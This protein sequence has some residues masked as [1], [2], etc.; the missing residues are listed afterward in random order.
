VA[1]LRWA[2][3]D[4]QRLAPPLQYAPFPKELA[5]RENQCA[6]SHPIASGS[7]RRPAFC[8]FATGGRWG[9]ISFDYLRSAVQIG[10]NFIEVV[11]PAQAPSYT[12][13][14]TCLRFPSIALSTA[15]L[16]EVQQI[17]PLVLR[18][19]HVNSGILLSSF[20]KASSRTSPA[21]GR[22]SSR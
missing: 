17:V 22:R 7:F 14:S 2:L 1:F 16:S 3:G 10:L 15:L 5:A 12:I 6:R 19:F 9:G 21:T 11:D 18:L 4:G 8:R 20:G 13:N